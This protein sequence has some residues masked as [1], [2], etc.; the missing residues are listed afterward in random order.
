M[1]ILNSIY[2][3]AKGAGSSL[4]QMNTS[5]EKLLDA[6]K[7]YYKAESKERNYNL[8][9]QKRARQDRFRLEQQVSETVQK[10]EKAFK[11]GPNKKLEE[12]F[13]K[14]IAGMLAAVLA[15]YGVKKLVDS[16]GGGGGGPTGGGP[17]GGCLLYTSPSPRDATRSRMP[18]SA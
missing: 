3:E 10:S 13:A 9:Q 7:K 1:S 11:G 12:G 2:G 17:T 16:Q 14:G 18:S 8:T 5:L 6:D 15:A 4:D